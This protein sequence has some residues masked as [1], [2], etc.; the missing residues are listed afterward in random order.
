[1]KSAAD[2]GI[3][4]LRI[5]AHSEHCEEYHWM[6]WNGVENVDKKFS[7]TFKTIQTEPSPDGPSWFKPNINQD[8]IDGLDWAVAEAAKH[9]IKLI[10]S[11][12]NHWQDFGGM[13]QY[14]R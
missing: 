5:W 13:A 1:M 4:V 10:M 12:T 14:A 8:G 2:K 3:N 7:N 11:L 6:Q 9:G